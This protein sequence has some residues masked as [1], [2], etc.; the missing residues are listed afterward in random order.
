MHRVV[1]TLAI[2]LNVA[3]AA[4]VLYAKWDEVVHNYDLRNSPGFDLFLLCVPTV[5]LIALLWEAR[6]RT[7]Q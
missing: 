1:N 6:R 3:F 4:L 7:R 2:V 5:S